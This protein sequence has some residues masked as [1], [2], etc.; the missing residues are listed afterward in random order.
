MILVIRHK[1]L[2]L[3]H[4]Q[5]DASKIPSQQL[6]RLTSILTLLEAA[7]KPQ[8]LNQPGFG[9]HSLSGDLAGFWSVKVTANYRVIFRFEGDDATDIDYIDYH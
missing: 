1:G 6:R 8:D 3:F 9:L 7:T 5:D 2:R 4:E